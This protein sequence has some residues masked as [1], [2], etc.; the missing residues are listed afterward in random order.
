MLA[1]A[2]SSQ[3]DRLRTSA[4]TETALT[5]PPKNQIKHGEGSLGHAVT[6]FVEW[7]AISSK[8]SASLPGRKSTVLPNSYFAGAKQ[9]F[10]PRSPRQSR[11][12]RGLLRTDALFVGIY[13]PPAVAR[14][15]Q[16]GQAV[17]Q[18][19]SERSNC[20]GHGAPDRRLV[21]LQRPQFAELRRGR[22][23][24]VGRWL[25]RRGSVGARPGN[26]LCSQLGAE[27]LVARVFGAGP[28]ATYNA[29]L[30]GPPVGLKLKYTRELEARRRFESGVF[31]GSVVFSF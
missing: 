31:C 20:A 16:G 30:G 19:G 29:K 14:E 21:D 26:R 3:P 1:G 28:I 18:S 15:D 12:V 9:M 10:R 24:A 27:S 4:L 6:N 7:L 17:A 13:L 11:L 2:L 22:A 8:M 5:R 23:F 25:P